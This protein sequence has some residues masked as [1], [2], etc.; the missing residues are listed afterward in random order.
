MFE[1]IITFVEGESSENISYPVT[2]V[3][4][5]EFETRLDFVEWM[6]RTKDIP[7]VV[8]TELLKAKVGE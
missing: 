8:N 1:A 6:S 3:Y 4:R 5:I 2:A 7:G